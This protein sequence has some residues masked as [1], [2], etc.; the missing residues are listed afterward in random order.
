MKCIRN[1][2][3]TVYSRVKNSEAVALIETGEW[4]HT[5]KSAWRAFKKRKRMRFRSTAGNR[6]SHNFLR[7]MWKGQQKPPISN[8]KS[9]GVQKHLQRVLSE[10]ERIFVESYLPNHA[11]K[12]LENS[13]ITLKEATNLYLKKRYRLNPNA[14]VIKTIKHVS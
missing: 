9:Y 13:E 7:R 14:R 5:S 10:P 1:A 6:P 8:S 4:V 2:R 3:G 11:I 12:K